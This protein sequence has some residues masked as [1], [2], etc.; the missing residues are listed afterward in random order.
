MTTSGSALRDEQLLDAMRMVDARL[1]GEA[2]M[3]AIDLLIKWMRPRAVRFL[4]RRF[5]AVDPASIRELLNDDLRS[6]VL[7]DRLALILAYYDRPRDAGDSTLPLSTYL[8][9]GRDSYLASHLR[10]RVVSGDYGA[11]AAAAKRSQERWVRQIHRM[12]ARGFLSEYERTEVDSVCETWQRRDYVAPAPPAPRHRLPGQPLYSD[13]RFLIQELASTR[14]TCKVGPEE[15]AFEARLGVDA[16]QFGIG[17]IGRRRTSG[18]LIRLVFTLL[19]EPF[20]LRTSTLLQFA[21][22][23]VLVEVPLDG[24]IEA[25][26]RAALKRA[27]RVR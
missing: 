8:F 4:M 6:F 24:A 3:R 13:R 25:A 27:G 1:E 15:R 22:S 2:V 18:R 17:A 19:P 21:A 16:Q 7:S 11:A 5:K 14:P 10:T 12:R 26:E 20:P 23:T 9:G